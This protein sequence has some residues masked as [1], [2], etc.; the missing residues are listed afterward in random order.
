MLANE[1]NMVAVLILGFALM[2]VGQFWLSWWRATIGSVAEKGF[3][4]PLRAA[5]S[6]G[7]NAVSG[8][9]FATFVALYETCPSL[10]KESNRLC[11]VQWYFRMLR[12]VARVFGA[13]RA[14]G[15]WAEREMATCA[16]YA[17]VC[18]D[19]RMRGTRAVWAQ[20][21]SY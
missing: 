14:V 21:R 6:L 9:D 13:I 5:A 8:R 19:Q 20:M 1:T 2:A 18:V 16:R 11:A 7:S 15:E 17:A 3:S 10:K 4:E 12:G